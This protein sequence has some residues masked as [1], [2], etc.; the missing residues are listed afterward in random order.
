MGLEHAHARLVIELARLRDG[1]RG[2]EL[3]LSDRP[4]ADGDALAERLGDAATELVGAAEEAVHAAARPS[5]DAGGLG[6]ELE[7]L[8]RV[9]AL[10]LDA[11]RRFHGEFAGA[12]Q[13]RELTRMS[14]RRRG[15]WPAWASAVAD[16][17]D[18]LWPALFSAES[19]LHDC[20]A[21]LGERLPVSTPSISIH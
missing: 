18:Q 6:G 2:L 13:T 16:A 4:Q 11:M 1:M 9:H 8:V 19:A 14:Q 3:T 17:L 21:E 7:R 12:G 5:G 20:L 10:L 15:E